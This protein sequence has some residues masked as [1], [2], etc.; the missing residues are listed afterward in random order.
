LVCCREREQLTMTYLITFAC[1]GARL[2]GDESGSVDRRHN[3][4][5]TPVLDANAKRIEIE[6]K[7]QDQLPYVLDER[8]RDVVLK[9]IQEVCRYRGWTLLAAHVRSNHVHTVVVAEPA[10]ERVMNDFKAYASRGLK[11][12]R[13]DP[14]DRK[15]W[16]HHGSTRWLWKPKEVI[17]AIQY[18]V[19]E[20]GEP[21]SVFE[22]VDP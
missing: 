2:H 10:P 1:Y 20:Q 16:A 22:N 12:T 17:A 18:V 14:P 13:L 21:M 11:D 5:G 7:L 3:V 15:R 19:N 8:R 6:T 9:S 4:P